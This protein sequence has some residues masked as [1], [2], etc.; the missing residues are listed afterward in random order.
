M[1]S[2]APPTKPQ[3]AASSAPATGLPF[4]DALVHGPVPLDRLSQVL[5]GLLP[6]LVTRA[7]CRP[8]YHVGPHAAGLAVVVGDV[9]VHGAQVLLRLLVAL[10][11]VRDEAALVEDV[12]DGA[13]GH[14][15]GPLRVIHE[16][17]LDL[18]PLSLEVLPPLVGEG[19]DV[20]LHA[21]APPPELPLGV[22]LRAV[23]LGGP[24]VLRAEVLSA[25]LPL[26]LL[27][28]RPAPPHGVKDRQQQDHDHNHHDD[29]ND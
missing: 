23:L 7:S 3:N 4:H 27:P 10:G 6:G 18:T 26:L 15:D 29:R 5:R 25:A 1:R 20:A 19:L 28:S 17:P 14:L 9:G 21:P 8:G 2:A 11:G 24:I 12:G 22:L 13:V 16:D